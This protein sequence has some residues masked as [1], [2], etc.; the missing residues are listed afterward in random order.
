MAMLQAV[1]KAH[2]ANITRGPSQYEAQDWAV[3]PCCHHAY[4]ATQARQFWEDGYPGLAVWDTC[5]CSNATTRP[6]A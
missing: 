4:N 6:V 5:V 2:V 3:V 1:A